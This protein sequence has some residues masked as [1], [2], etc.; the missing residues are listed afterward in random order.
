MYA[1][2]TNM[3]YGTPEHRS[4]IEKHGL[5]KYHRR[6]FN[7]F[8]EKFSEIIADDTAEEVQTMQPILRPL[9]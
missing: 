3:G 9:A 8:V 1:W 5:C 2:K 4:A 6:S 7:I